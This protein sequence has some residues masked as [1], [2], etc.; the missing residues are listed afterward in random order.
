VPFA[1]CLRCRSIA[2]GPEDKAVKLCLSCHGQDL[3]RAR[4]TQEQ[5][6]VWRRVNE[7]KERRLLRAERRQDWINSGRA[8]SDYSSDASEHGSQDLWDWGQDDDMNYSA[9]S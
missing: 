5:E 4:A 6:R 1:R 8:L 3:E 2:R 9:H 7:Q